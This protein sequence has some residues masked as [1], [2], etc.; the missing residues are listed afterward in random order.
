MVDIVVGGIP[1]VHTNQ[2]KSDNPRRPP[3]KKRSSERRKNAADR[4]RSVR[5][6]VVVTLSGRTERRQ[7]PDRR[8]G[9]D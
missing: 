8:K 1:P 9:T 3:G 5:D 2:G 7:Q 4:R 6:G